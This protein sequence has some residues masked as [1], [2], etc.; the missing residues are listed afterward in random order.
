MTVDALIY[1][2]RYFLLKYPFMPTGHNCW[3]LT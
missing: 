2:L 3:N 1:E